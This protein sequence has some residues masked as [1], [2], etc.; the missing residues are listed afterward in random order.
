MALTSY[1]STAWRDYVDDW[2]ESHDWRDPWAE[3]RRPLLTEELAME[4]PDEFDARADWII[5]N[6]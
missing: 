3:T 6:L 4:N 1:D 2:D 5:K